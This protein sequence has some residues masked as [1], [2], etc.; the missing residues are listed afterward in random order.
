M[1]HICNIN[2]ANMAP[3]IKCALAPHL[4]SPLRRNAH[5]PPASTRLD[6]IGVRRKCIARGMWGVRVCVCVCVCGGPS[7]GLWSALTRILLH[8]AKMRAALQLPVKRI[9]VKIEE[10]DYI[11]FYFPAGLRPLNGLGA[12]KRPRP[13][14]IK[15]ADFVTN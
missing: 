4:H 12:R 2:M 10:Y 14:T 13:K 7:K 9:W 6:K 1:A 8:A 11:H 5:R 3:K 15:S